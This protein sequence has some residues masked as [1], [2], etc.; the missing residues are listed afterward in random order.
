M[1][2]LVEIHPDLLAGD[3]SEGEGDFGAVLAAYG[4]P[5]DGQ[6]AK[7]G[8]LGRWGVRRRAG[9]QCLFGEGFESL[10]G[11]GAVGERGAVDLQVGVDPR[12][13]AGRSEVA[14]A[15]RLERC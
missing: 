5:G 10:S 2:Q 6:T 8:E 15:A 7:G 9:E 13:R 11:L 14:L 3:I 12:G 1:A 4:L